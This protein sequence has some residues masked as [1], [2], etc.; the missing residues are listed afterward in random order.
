MD[1]LTFR[2]MFA[3]FGIVL[4][5][6]L[7]FLFGRKANLR[8]YLM[9]VGVGFLFGLLTDIIFR[10]YIYSFVMG[11]ILAGYV[12]K[13]PGKWIPRIRVG[14]LTAAL[15]LIYVYI[16]NYA[17]ILQT[18][19]DSIMEAVLAAGVTATPEQVPVNFLTYLVMNSLIIIS[20]VVLGAI[21]GGFLRSLIKPVARKE[22]EPQ[23]TAA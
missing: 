10:T 14:G 3:A 7:A 2:A 6:I 8:T 18:P 5:G 20:L 23:K 9:P 13:E 4:I 22:D 11:G 19:L 21:V 15:I 17:Y 1:E 16:P 12:L